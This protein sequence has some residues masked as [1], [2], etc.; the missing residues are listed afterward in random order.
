MDAALWN[1]LVEERFLARL[2]GYPLCDRELTVDMRKEFRV[3][4]GKVSLLLFWKHINYK[5]EI[6]GS[7]YTIGT[8]QI[9]LPPMSVFLS[10]R[11]E[12]AEID[13]TWKRHCQIQ[14]AAFHWWN[15][16]W[17]ISIGPKKNGNDQIVEEKTR[18]INRHSGWGCVPC[19]ENA[20]AKH[21]YGWL[22]RLQ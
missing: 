14:F 10:D 9:L 22:W 15:L 8:A 7:P 11:Q 5:K 21:L 19:S 18:I 3:Q 2:C 6:L 12:T 13:G 4:N 16:F 17:K 1:E 20:S